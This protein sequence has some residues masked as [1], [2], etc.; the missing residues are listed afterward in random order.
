MRTPDGLRWAV[1]MADLTRSTLELLKASKDALEAMR[2]LGLYL[3][4]YYKE[5]RRLEAAIAGD[6]KLLE[7]TRM[8][9]LD[10]LRRTK[11]ER[12]R[13]QGKQV[14]CTRHWAYAEVLENKPL[15]DDPEN[16][17]IG[18]RSILHLGNTGNGRIG[19]HQYGPR[20]LAVGTRVELFMFSVHGSLLTDFRV[21]EN[22]L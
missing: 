8:Q 6:E 15:C 1:P 14:I 17:M 10:K 19:W 20:D 13:T 21:L 3:E 7:G 4:G 16:Q 2:S 12:A 9:I 18:S 22:N 11:G 5:M